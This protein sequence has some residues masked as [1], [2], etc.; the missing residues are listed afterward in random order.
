MA[1]DTHRVMRHQD[2]WQVKR[3]GGKRASHV[4]GTKAEAEK[5]AREISRNQDTELQIHNKDGKIGSSDSHG[6]DPRGNG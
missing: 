2:G 4:T 1:R 6:N 3:D 5:L